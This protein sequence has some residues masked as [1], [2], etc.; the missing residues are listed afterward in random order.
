MDWEEIRWV[1]VMLVLLLSIF[2][3]ILLYYHMLLL[4]W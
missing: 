3:F 2:G 1:G 4:P